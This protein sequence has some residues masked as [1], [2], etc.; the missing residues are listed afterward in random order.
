MTRAY[1][2][3]SSAWRRNSAQL[4]IHDSFVRVHTLNEDVA[5]DMA[6]YRPR[7][8][9]TAARR[10]RCGVLM[11]DHIP[12][13]LHGGRKS[14]GERADSRKLEKLPRPTSNS[15]RTRFKRPTGR[16]VELR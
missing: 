9:D 4:G 13:P 6:F 3:A 16:V 5:K 12:K 7:R 15:T 2:Q 14:S 8:P 11:L 1:R 10:V